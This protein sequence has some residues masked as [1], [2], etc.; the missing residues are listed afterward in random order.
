MQLLSSV[1]SSSSLIEPCQ[2]WLYS[3]I[4]KVSLFCTGRSLNDNE[5]SRILGVFL[6]DSYVSVLG[7]VSLSRNQLTQV[8]GQLPLFPQ[9]DHADLGYNAITS[10]QS[11]A[12]NFTKKLHKLSLRNKSLS[13]IEA[14]AFQGKYF[15]KVLL[16]LLFYL[17]NVLFNLQA[18]SVMVQ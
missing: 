12:F 17:L 18:I 14:G 16:E 8:P 10:I 3:E 1:C 15:W 11:G 2:C 7:K 4:G 6:N 9:L 5:A 13:N